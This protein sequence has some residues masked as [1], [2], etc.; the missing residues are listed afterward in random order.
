M[1]VCGVVRTKCILVFS[2]QTSC[3][4]TAAVCRSAPLRYIGVD[5]WLGLSVQMV[6][7]SLRD[8]LLQVDGVVDVPGD[9]VDRVGQVEHS[10]FSCGT[11]FTLPPKLLLFVFCFANFLN[12]L[13]RGIVAGAVCVPVCVR[14]WLLN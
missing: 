9:H 5:D 6:A 8:P 11:G 3:Y 14:D 13:D 7:Q 4:F 1:C 10:K 2:N 12:Y